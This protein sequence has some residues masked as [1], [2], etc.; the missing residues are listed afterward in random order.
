MTTRLRHRIG[1]LEQAPQNQ[2]MIVVSMAH[3]ERDRRDLVDEALAEAG[4]VRS[5][6]DLL[7]VRMRF[8]PEPGQPL[9]RVSSVWPPPD[10][11]IVERH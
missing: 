7:I 5:A 11:A 8:N 3:T 4:I 2:R 1:R 6:N 9:A 10:P